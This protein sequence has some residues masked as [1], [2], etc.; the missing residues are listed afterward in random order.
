MKIKEYTN[1]VTGQKMTEDDLTEEQ[2][3]MIERNR[4]NWIIAWI[5]VD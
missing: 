3:D 1:K 5:D 2:K 4:E